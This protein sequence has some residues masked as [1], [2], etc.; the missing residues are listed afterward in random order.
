MEKVG[1]VGKVGK[2]VGDEGSLSC[3]AGE[4]SLKVPLPT[5]YS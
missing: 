4:T 3:V 5:R 1:K 2:M